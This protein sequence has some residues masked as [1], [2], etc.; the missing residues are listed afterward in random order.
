MSEENSISEIDAIRIT[1]CSRLAERVKWVYI[2]NDASARELEKVFVELGIIEEYERPSTRTTYSLFGTNNVQA[3]KRTIKPDDIL[4][5][6]TQGFIVGTPGCGK[7]TLLKYLALKT[8]EGHQRLPVFIELKTISKESFGQSD[9]LAELL[10]NK[11]AS[12]LVFRTPR[13]RET[14]RDFFFN[15]LAA[16]EM[17]IF[18]DGLDEVRGTDI[19]TNLCNAITEFIHS[20]FGRNTIIISARPY[21][22]QARF[23][24]L[25]EMEILPFDFTQIKD[26]LLHYYGDDPSNKYLLKALDQ[27][28]QLRELARS[29]LLLSVI[30]NLH[31]TQNGLAET[32]LEIYRQ[33]VLKLAKQLDRE[34][35]IERA[36]FYIKDPDETIKLDFLKQVSFERLFIDPVE[37]DETDQESVRLIFTGD[38]LLEKAKRFVEQSNRTDINP[39]WLASDVKAT[40][41]L[42]EVGAD[43]YAFTHLTI[44]EYLAAVSLSNNRYCEQIFCHSYFNPTLVEMEVLPMTLGLVKDPNAFYATLEQLPESLN[45]TNLR[46]R[47][48]GLAYLQEIDKE[49]LNKLIDPLVDFVSER[50]YE[51]TP[52]ADAVVRSFA[53][54][55]GYFSDQIVDRMKSLLDNAQGPE[56]KL[57][58]Y[59]A[60]HIRTVLE[61]I[62]GERAKKVLLEAMKH[63]DRTVRC[64]AIGALDD[65]DDEL[66][67]NAMIEALKD[68]DV[69]V[70][71]RA[72]S[73]LGDMGDERAIDP[74]VE[75]LNEK[76]HDQGMHASYGLRK[77]GGE[78]VVEAVIKAFS[79]NNIDGR[80][81]AI[82]TLKAIGSELPIDG[83]LLALKDSN[84][85]IRQHAAEALRGQR[86]DHV[87]DALLLA[88]RDSDKGVQEKAGAALAS[89]KGERV[90][91]GLINA[92]K[93]DDSNTRACAAK[94]LS[95]TKDDVAVDALNDAIEDR[96][97]NVRLSSVDA[98]RTIE[99]AKAIKCLIN[100]LSSEHVEVRSQAVMWIG[101][102]GGQLATGFMLKALT[103]ES[104]YVRHKAARSLW[105]AP[106]PEAIDGLLNAL[107]DKDPD[108]C[109]NAARALSRFSENRALEGLHKALMSANV[110]VRQRIPQML[111]HVGEPQVVEWLIEALDDKDAN[112]RD[113]A[114]KFLVEIGGDRAVDGLLLVL[115]DKN[116]WVRESAVI[117]LG[118]IG[119]RRA[120]EPLIEALK[121]EDHGVCEH[122]ARALEKLSDVRAVDALIE[123]LNADDRNLTVWNAERALITIGGKKAIRALLK[124]P[125]ANPQNRY[126]DVAS[127]INMFNNK[128]AIEIVRK[129]LNDEDH[130]IRLNAIKTLASLKDKLVLDC[131]THALDDDDSEIR[132]IAAKTVYENSKEGLIDSLKDREND[133]RDKIK[134]AVENVSGDRLVGALLYVLK[135][136]D[137]F[138]REDAAKALENI[139]TI[140]IGKGLLDAIYY[141]DTF[142]RR[143]SSEIVGYY[144]TSDEVL[145]ALLDLA[146]NDPIVEV[147]QVAGE[148]LN[149]LNYKLKREPLMT[150]SSQRPI[151]IFFS[152]SHSD[153][154]LRDKLMKHLAVLKRQGII[155]DWHDRQ[156]GAGDEWAGEI[157]RH[158]NSARIILLLVSADFLASDYCYDI[159][160]KR[161]ME[162]HESGDA[163]VIPIILRPCNWHSAPFG[164]L[165][166]LPKDAKPVTTW[167]DTDEALLNIAQGIQVVAGRLMQ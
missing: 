82:E 105:L 10:L 16:G 137:H 37:L 128:Q 8:L 164:K 48:R 34:K 125:K 41:L 76:E 166:A 9:D 101:E 75:N 50:N 26:F 1:Y 25:K 14:F 119:G 68:K 89:I 36:H 64:E 123:V 55:G 132:N 18:L 60:R 63:S 78:K 97:K 142:V 140:S 42:R 160:M 153:E 96:D 23:E 11:A 21:A 58:W 7:T 74:L 99:G 157:D 53:G 127:L 6:K 65:A 3:E 149:K 94:A 146:K 77:I 67:F 152:Y 98:L 45:Y 31:K 46:L 109:I 83:L 158:L 111:V 80:Y 20:D 156:I 133:I 54:T 110:L 116:K 126:T 86:S 12:S 43:I 108:V 62:G 167:T 29:P 145:N 144:L 79:D 19:F 13:E 138:V 27:R 47:A 5:D 112:V 28:P 17:A 121:D 35:S 57:D 114:V 59:V 85:Y 49:H 90:I 91:D 117:G 115:N 124:A 130:D 106:D 122:A 155:A 44:Q 72:A 22:L 134:V 135:N 95:G 102:L 93:D 163:R 38:T 70:R 15:R 39:Y 159:E 113:E 107:K 88:L 151:E 103:D 87:I 92:L 32:R 61:M 147:R 131:F 118:I 120:L 66:V 161:A 2:F 143:K 148:A 81:W 165:Q 24:G 100:A 56:D 69:Y 139:D 136:K 71:D 129:L 73:I 4:K 52:Y 150:D 104:P 84:E 51:G 141:E 162:R 33:I 30:A 154:Q 40:P